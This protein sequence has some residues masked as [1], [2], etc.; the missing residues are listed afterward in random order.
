MTVVIVSLRLSKFVNVLY[1]G[2]VMLL[3]GTP[4]PAAILTH[5]Q[6]IVWSTSELIRAR[7]AL[8]SRP[9]QVTEQYGY[10]PSDVISAT[11]LGTVDAGDVHVIRVLMPVSSGYYGASAS[12]WTFV[13]TIVP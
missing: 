4:R 12:L 2:F 10:Y 3:S 1:L 9:P 11:P 6:N 7:A 8:V 13:G 5:E